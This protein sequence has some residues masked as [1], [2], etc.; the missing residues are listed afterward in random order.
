[1]WMGAF[2][3]MTVTFVHRFTHTH[4]HTIYRHHRF[5]HPMFAVGWTVRPWLYT[6]GLNELI[7]IIFIFITTTSTNNQAPM[8]LRG[9]CYTCIMHRLCRLIRDKMG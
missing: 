6:E 1:M 7:T 9:S 5:M 4:T 2:V 8:L 3:S